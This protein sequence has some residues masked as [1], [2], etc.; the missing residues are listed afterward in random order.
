MPVQF[1]TPKQIAQY[2]RYAG[3]PSPKQL[4]RYF[5]LD[6]AHLSVID[7]WREDHTRLE[8]AIQ[9]CTVRF[10]GNFL[11]DWA[12]LPSEVLARLAEQLDIEDTSV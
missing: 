3:I 9:L 1:L 6:D 7:T 2:S 10:L 8:F 5:H 12:E 4:A 11:T